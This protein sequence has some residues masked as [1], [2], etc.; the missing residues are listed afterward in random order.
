M[1]NSLSNSLSFIRWENALVR[2]A[3]VDR[4]LD[5]ILLELRLL[6]TIDSSRRTE[7]KNLA[8]STW[9]IFFLSENFSLE[10]FF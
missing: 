3:L 9:Q 5:Q 6:D 1:C 8:E 10:S 2:I 4:F 7:K